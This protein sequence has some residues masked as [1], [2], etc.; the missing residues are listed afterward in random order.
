M[1]TPNTSERLDL[2]EFEFD[3][4]CQAGMHDRRG[5]TGPAEW[6]V[7]CKPGCGCPAT[8]VFSCDACLAYALQQTRVRRWNHTPC[9]RSFVSS[10]AATVVGTERIR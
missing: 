4:P 10:F 8:Q 6:I 5:H 7:T 2:T 9:G 1:S 3:I